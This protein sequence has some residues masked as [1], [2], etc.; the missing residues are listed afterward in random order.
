MSVRRE[1]IFIYRDIIKVD[2]SFIDPI[3][4]VDKKTS[5]LIN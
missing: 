2:Y 5:L 3:F 4:T 1:Y